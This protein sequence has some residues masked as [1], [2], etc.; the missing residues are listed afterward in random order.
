MGRFFYFLTISYDNI[1]DNI[2]EMSPI[3][4]IN[5]SKLMEEEGKGKGIGEKK[6]KRD[7]ERDKE[8]KSERE[9]RR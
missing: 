4:K 3:L 1:K 6:R 5:K 2:Y 9:F 8:R 7:R